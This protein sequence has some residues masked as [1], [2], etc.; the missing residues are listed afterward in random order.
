MASS[1]SK[2]DENRAVRESYREREEALKKRQANELQRLRDSHSDEFLSM[3]KAQ[4]KRE[5]ELSA[6]T[7]H[8]INAS[9][10]KHTY[11]MN[12]MKK[13]HHKELKNLHQKNRDWQEA[14]A[15]DYRNISSRQ[16]ASHEAQQKSQQERHYNIQKNQAEKSQRMLDNYRERHRDEVTDFK[17]NVRN[18]YEEKRNFQEA[19]H[20]DEKSK[21]VGDFENYRRYKTN[22]IDTMNRDQAAKL[23]RQ[24]NFHYDMMHSQQKEFAMQYEDMRD[25]AKDSHK[26]TQRRYNKALSLIH[27]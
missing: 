11:D 16:R 24:D 13:A 9:D 8:A 25:E 22:Q 20:F 27:I 18:E 6:K 19:R 2:H 15:R 10:R 12:K 23:E 1:I 14:R 4:G 3:S 21:I 5:R 7:A 17:R 26:Q